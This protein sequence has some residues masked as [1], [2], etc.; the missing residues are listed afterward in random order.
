M[1]DTNAWLDALERRHL[2]NL[3]RSELTRALRALSSC[4]VERRA[5]L[6]GG[7]ALEGAGKRAA[8]ALFYGPLHFLTIDALVRAAGADALKI[9]TLVDLGCGTG[10]GAAAWALACRTA[11]SVTGIDRHAWAVQEANWTY[12]QLGIQGRARTG[13][14]V[15]DYPTARSGR[16]AIL[17]AYT[18]NE[19]PEAARSAL[20]DRIARSMSSGVSVLIVEAIAKRD[21]DWW[22]DWTERLAVVGAR[23]DEWRFPAVLP[24]ILRQIAKGAGLDPREL[25]ARSIARL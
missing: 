6:A 2:A 13:D 20:L 3:T 24:P 9:D 25:T 11:P 8:F 5:K 19:L 4:Y 12:R 16:F 18:V 23:S 14:V 22:P 15:R 10:V 7:A 21:K 1:I 17:L